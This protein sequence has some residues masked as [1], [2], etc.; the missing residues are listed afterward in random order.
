M[1]FFGRKGGKDSEPA[2]DAEP[3]TP[4]SVPIAGDK[5]CGMCQRHDGAPC[6][7]VDRKGRHCEMPVCPD[8]QVPVHGS[9]YCVRHGNTMKALHVWEGDEHSAKLVTSR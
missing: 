8:H 4:P 5:R 1:G 3:P 2:I 6:V 9:C 7:Y